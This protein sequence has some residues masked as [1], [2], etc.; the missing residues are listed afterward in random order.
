MAWGVTHS[1]ADCAGQLNNQK[2]EEIHV[3]KEAREAKREALNAKYPGRNVCI[4]KNYHQQSPDDR[5][6]FHE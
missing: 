2:L 6:I 5:T 4:C 1:N 3:R